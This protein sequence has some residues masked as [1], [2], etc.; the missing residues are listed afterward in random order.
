MDEEGCPGSPPWKALFNKSLAEQR[1]ISDGCR[2]KGDDPDPTKEW[3]NAAAHSG[4]PR[5][6]L[7][8]SGGMRTF[9]GTYHIFNSNLVQASGG[10]VDLYFH[11]WL[12]EV[13]PGREATAESRMAQALAKGH[14]NTKFYAEEDLA[15]YSKILADE[16][17]RFPATGAAW[18]SEVMATVASHKELVRPYNFAAGYSQWR[19]VNLAFA[20][21]KASGIDYR[22]EGGAAWRLNLQEFSLCHL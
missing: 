7:A 2:D 21:I 16:S 14:P 19:K 17:P 15:L 18:V 12:D 5:F 4:V 9:A 6:A 3:P 22:C 10:A 13:A 1:A 11:V 8:I 20:A